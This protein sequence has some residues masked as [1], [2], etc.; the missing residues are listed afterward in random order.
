MR[1]L[2]GIYLC[3]QVRYELKKIACTY[4]ITLKSLVP[5][6]L[7][8]IVNNRNSSYYSNLQ[9]VPGPRKLKNIEVEEVIYDKIKLAAYDK[10]MKLNDFINSALLMTIHYYDINVLIVNNFH[11]LKQAK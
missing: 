5:T 11:S 10:Q 9:N 2:K 4:H 3:P 6:L 7:L 1:K 8:H